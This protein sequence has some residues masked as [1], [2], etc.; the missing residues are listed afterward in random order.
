M[1][2]GTGERHEPDAGFVAARLLENYTEAARELLPLTVW[3]P[4]RGPEQRYLVAHRGGGKYV[5]A[6]TRPGAITEIAS[7]EVHPELARPHR[8]ADLLRRWRSEELGLVINPDSDTEFRIPADVIPELAELRREP[9]FESRPPDNSPMAPVEPPA[10]IGGFRFVAMVDG[11]DNDGKPIVAPERGT[12]LDPEEQRRIIEYLN[13]GYPIQVVNGPVTDIFEPRRGSVVPAHTRTDGTWVWSDG[14]GYYLETYG[15]APEAEFYA[16][17]K[18]H[19][20]V[21]PRPS[22]STLEAAGRALEERQ[23]IAAELYQ[24]WQGEQHRQS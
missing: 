13:G 17:I 24:R 1:T 19:H 3:L 7:P 10:E 9:T 18:E 12:V 14:I 8:F 23:F 2:E 22:E 11:V 15:L 4:V 21:C 5:R 16:A 20:Y 6:Y